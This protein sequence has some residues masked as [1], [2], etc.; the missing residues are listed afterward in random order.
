MHENYDLRQEQLNK[1]SLLSSKKFLE[2]L[3]DIFSNHVVS[4]RYSSSI[5]D[6]VNWKIIHHV[7]FL[8]FRGNQLEYNGSQGA[9]GAG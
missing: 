7:K 2:D 9:I 6:V 4:T 3:L 8:A 1:S 5:P